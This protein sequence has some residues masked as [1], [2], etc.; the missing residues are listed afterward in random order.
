MAYAA[1][2][3]FTG[4]ELETLKLEDKDLAIMAIATQVSLTALENY[5]DKLYERE[6]VEKN[7]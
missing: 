2:H 4:A 7:Y 1:H 3:H 5:V 6:D